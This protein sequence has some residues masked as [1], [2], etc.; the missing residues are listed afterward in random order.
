MLRAAHDVKGLPIAAV[1]GEIGRV[2]DLYF[3]DLIWTARYLVVDTGT[4]LPGR[5]VLI[6][7]MSVKSATLRDRVEV[8]LTREQVEKSPPVDADKPVDRQEEEALS[9]YYRYRYYWEGPY[10]WG[11]LGYPGM[12]PIPA[13]VAGDSV[14]DEMAAREGESA[15]GDPTLRSVRDVVGYHIAARDGEVGHVEDFLIDERAWAIR[16]LVVD[17]RNWWPGK[18]VLLSPEWIK[19][20]SWADSRVY[21]DLG[22]DE[23]KGAPPYD[24]GHE[25]AREYETRLFEH[26]GRRK[27]W[28][29]EDR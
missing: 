1:D 14:V 24:P 3:D 20:V 21:V 11:L 17:T 26:H 7:P 22:R 27:Y 5:R 9:R 12:P 23:I 19:T 13:P 6:S 10:R 8:S 25:V 16:Y 4:W 2:K 29:W 28:E 15:L 18:R